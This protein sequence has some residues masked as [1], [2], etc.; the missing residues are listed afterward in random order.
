MTYNVLLKSQS[1]SV[2]LQIEFSYEQIRKLLC[3]VIKEKLRQI[4][5]LIQVTYY[6]N[7]NF[8][9]W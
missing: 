1:D 9:S 6:D 5:I 4:I 8:N 7:E 3:A 2:I